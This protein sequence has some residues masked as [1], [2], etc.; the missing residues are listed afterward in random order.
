MDK[1]HK[2]IV[3]LPV[4]TEW[5]AIF[6]TEKVKMRRARDQVTQ[7]SFSVAAQCLEWKIKM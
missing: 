5:L 6:K 7:N 4:M 3:S 2:I 1:Q